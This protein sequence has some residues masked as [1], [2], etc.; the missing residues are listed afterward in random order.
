MC[1]TTHPVLVHQRHQRRAHEPVL[2]HSPFPY[3]HLRFTCD[4]LPS[5]K[6]IPIANYP[7]TRTIRLQPSSRVTFV[8]CLATGQ[9]IAQT[10]HYST[11]PITCE[12]S[13]S[14]SLSLF[15]SGGLF[16]VCDRISV[17]ANSPYRTNNAAGRGYI[18]RA[19]LSYRL[20]S[21]SQ[22]THSSIL[23]QPTQNF[24]Q[25]QSTP[26]TQLQ[27]WATAAVHPREPATADPT[28]RA[29]AVL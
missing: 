9:R 28:A 26:T 1:G 27:S 4:L 18:S 29:T 16:A 15:C 12:Q 20:D 3:H 24:N 13:C 6:K 11:Q 10:T 21:S 22:R 25:F 23:L 8:E 2:H 7:L 19:S 5:K 17:V 14:G